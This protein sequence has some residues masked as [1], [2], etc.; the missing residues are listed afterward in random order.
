MTRPHIVGFSGSSWRPAKSR[1]LVEAIGAGLRQRYALGID[2]LDLV[3]A[4]PGIAAFTRD[5]LDDSA[6]AVVE[7]IEGAAAL[8]IGWPV[9]HGSYPRLFTHLFDLIEPGA[10]PNPPS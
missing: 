6:R 5:R 7:A 9:V 3:D 1:T 10:L 2:V 8:V 4:G